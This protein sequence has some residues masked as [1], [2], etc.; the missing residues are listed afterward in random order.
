[1]HP[2][3]ESRATRRRRGRSAIVVALLAV[4]ALLAAACGSDDSSDSS[5]SSS[6][7]VPDGPAIVLGA[8]DFPES[9]VLSEVYKQA[10]EAAGYQ[11]RVQ[12]LGGYRDILYGAF[13]SGDVNFAL[14]YAASTLNFLAKPDAPAGTDVDENVEQ[15]TPLLEAKDI[16]VAE[17]SEAVN[18]N[19][20]VMTKERSDDLGITKISE[21]GTKGSNLKLG[22]PSDCLTQAFCIPGLQRVYD[23]DLSGNFVALDTAAASALAEDQFDVGV[24]FSTDPEATDPDFVVLEDDRGM[25]AADNI[26]PVM[27]QSLVD[28]YGQ[29]LVDLVNRI[30]AALTTQ[31]VSEMNSAYIVDK[32]DASDIA[33]AFLEQHDLL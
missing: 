8:Q 24:L 17:P 33:K 27:A 16:V 28:A 30:S 11:A 19:V 31:N 5:D 15:M 22:A 3:T 26:T 1:M 6:A 32:E 18:N 21:L 14:E 10:F 25:S 20:F 13:S 23:I 7:S 12:E 29:D 9:L 4:L 2:T